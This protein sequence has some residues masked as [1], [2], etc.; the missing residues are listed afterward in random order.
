MAL[1]LHLVFYPAT[2]VATRNAGRDERKPLAEDS[3]GMGTNVQ[4]LLE[5]L[6]GVNRGDRHMSLDS[7][8]LA[9]KAMARLTSF[10]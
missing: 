1:C 9:Q 8:S 7:G 4:Q 6:V 2:A 3:T 10:D 5:V